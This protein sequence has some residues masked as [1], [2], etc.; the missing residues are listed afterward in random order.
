SYGAQE[1]LPAGMN[2]CSKEEIDFLGKLGKL[3]LISE[4]RSEM[5]EGSVSVEVEKINGS[6][7]NVMGLPVIELYKELSDFI[8][9]KSH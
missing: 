1:C 9:E 8:T 7:F 3:N 5:K 6:Y 4:S 2:P